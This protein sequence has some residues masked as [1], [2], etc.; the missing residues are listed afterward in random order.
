MPRMPH[1]SG[2]CDGAWH[3]STWPHAR[4]PLVELT[5]RSQVSTLLKVIVVDSPGEAVIDAGTRSVPEIG[6]NCAR[7]TA[8]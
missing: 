4:P 8:W 6:G 5:P 1:R 2:R 3:G 7:V